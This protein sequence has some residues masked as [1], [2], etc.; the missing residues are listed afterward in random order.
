MNVQ[1]GAVWHLDEDQSWP[2]WKGIRVDANDPEGGLVWDDKFFQRAQ[3]D[4]YRKKVA[5]ELANSI[6]ELYDILTS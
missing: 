5:K 6:R 1:V 4:T 3:S 2:A